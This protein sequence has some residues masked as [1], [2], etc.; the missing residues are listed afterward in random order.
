MA[1]LSAGKSSDSK[2]LKAEHLKDGVEVEMTIDR[3]VFEPIKRD[4][5]TEQQKLVLYFRG[6]ERGLVLN[7]TNIDVLIGCYGDDQ[8]AMV[9]QT[10]V[11]FRTTTQFKS[12][13]VPCLRLRAP[14][15]PV[16]QEE[17]VF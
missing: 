7:N 16:D 5:G 15:R 1:K 10:I 14:T 13:V 8:E 12:Q 2:Y 11:L 17:V 6:R 4:D 3:I 9:G